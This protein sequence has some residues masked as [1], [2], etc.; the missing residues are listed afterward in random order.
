MMN[1]YCAFLRQK[2]EIRKAYL[3]KKLDW[4]C[5]Q[6]LDLILIAIQE[7]KEF[8]VSNAMLL[9]E[10]GSPATIH[11]KLQILRDFD[12]VTASFTTDKRTKFIKP[13]N[14]AIAYYDE[15]ARAFCSAT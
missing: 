8:S 6:L 11:K 10:V 2:N 7:K 3:P 15:I 5:L 12:L 1:N 13:T 14:K 9:T 4:A